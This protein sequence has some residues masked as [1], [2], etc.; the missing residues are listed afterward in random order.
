MKKSTI[1]ILG[2]LIGLLAIAVYY[3]VAL[4][5]INIHSADFWGFL[6]IIIV[7]A[8]IYYILKKRIRL[9]EIKH[10]KGTI[11]GKDTDSKENGK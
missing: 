9:N 11:Y 1:K 7:I 2:V 10:Y 8:L 3:Y 5:A 6:F 4:P